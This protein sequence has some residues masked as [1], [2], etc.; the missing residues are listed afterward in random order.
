MRSKLRFPAVDPGS[1]LY[2]RWLLVINTAVMYNLVFVVARAVFW[3]LEP[4]L[5]P[6]WLLLDYTADT[7]YL[8]DTL[9]RMHEGYLEH[10]ILVTDP[11]S[12]RR[13][14]FRSKH[15]TKELVKISVISMKS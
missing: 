9:V 2:Y 14:Y 5:G 13:Q 4:A 12:L 3:Q 6:G 8:L 11:A 7:L 10:G 1:Y 15:L